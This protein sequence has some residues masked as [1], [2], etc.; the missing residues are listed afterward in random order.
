MNVVS[1]DTNSCT[2]EHNGQQYSFTKNRQGE[3]NLS[4]AGGGTAKSQSD[5]PQGVWDLAQRT[6]GGTL[7]RS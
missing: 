4:T 7:P 1:Q 2:I 3:I 5:V 6:L